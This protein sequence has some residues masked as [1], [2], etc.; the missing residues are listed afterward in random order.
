MNLRGHVNCTT[1]AVALDFSLLEQQGKDTEGMHYFSNGDISRAKLG[2]HPQ[3]SI[4]NTLLEKRTADISTMTPQ[5]Q[6]AVK[7]LSALVSKCFHC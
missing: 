1:N 7:M 2:L 4:E 3:S 6:L 5:P